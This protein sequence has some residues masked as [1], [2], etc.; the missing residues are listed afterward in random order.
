MALLIETGANVPGANSFVTLDEIKAYALARGLIL[1]DDDEVL[2][3]KA[4]LAMDYIKSVEFDFGGERTYTDQ[5]LPFPRIGLYI[6]DVLFSDVAI[7]QQA[8]DAQCQIVWEISTNGVQL[9][10][11]SQGAQIKRKR[12]GPL[13]TEWFEPGGSPM[14][15]SLDAIWWPIMLRHRFTLRTQRV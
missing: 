3:Q 12:V 15:R 6:Y 1:P 13:E 5:P 7:P 4:I 9:F 14:L 10:P 2:E 8:K 11:T